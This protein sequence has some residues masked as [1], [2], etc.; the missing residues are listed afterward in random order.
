MNR[1]DSS[2][3]LIGPQSRFPPENRESL[4]ES[5]SFY[6]SMDALSDHLFWAI[7][8]RSGAQPAY[9]YGFN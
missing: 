7:V 4:A 1:Q 3:E 8:D 9:N 5:W 2:L 6:L